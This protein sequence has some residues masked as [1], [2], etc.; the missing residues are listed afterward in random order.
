MTNSVRLCTVLAMKR[1]TP[2]LLQAIETNMNGE[3][4]LNVSPNATLIITYIGYEKMSVQVNGQKTIKVQMQEEAQTLET[5]VVTAMG[6]KK[7]A[8]SLTYSTQQVEGDELTRAK[9]PN[10]KAL[11]TT[12]PN[13]NDASGIE[14]QFEKIMTQKWLAIYPEGNEAW[15]EQR[16]TGYPRLFKV[17]VN[18]S[19]GT[20]NTNIMIR[21]LPFP[22]DLQKSNPTQY[23]S[24]KSA[25]GGADNGGTRL[26][27]DTGKNNL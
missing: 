10:M 8:A 23:N 11:I 14:E 15:T 12:T 4:S 22:A 26:W 16:R 17:K 2:L 5:V 1:L 18:K 7:K 6:I 20:I 19:G 9:D 13:W 21:R 27:W 24:L 3:F 25:L